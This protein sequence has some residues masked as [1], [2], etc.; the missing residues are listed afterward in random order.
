MDLSEAINLMKELSDSCP[1]L[2]GNDF[3]LGPSKLLHTNV[4]GY[5]IHMTGE[6]D[7]NTRICLSNIAAKKKLAIT[8]ETNSV[9]IYRKKPIQIETT[10]KSK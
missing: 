7:E 6:F 4:D 3:L 5:E 2:R 9:M 1:G 10:A 8:M